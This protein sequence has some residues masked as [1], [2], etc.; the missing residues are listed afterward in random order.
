M[1]DIKVDCIVQKIETISNPDYKK[2]SSLK[3]A[4][5]QVPGTFYMGKT[6]EINF[7]CCKCN[8]LNNYKNDFREKETIKAGRLH[9]KYFSNK[10]F[11]DVF[12]DFFN[13]FLNNKGIDT[14]GS[15]IYYYSIKNKLARFIYFKC[16]KCEAKY[17]MTYSIELGEE[18]PPQPDLIHI[19]N[20]YQV[21]FDEKTFLNLYD[22][23]SRRT[24]S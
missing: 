3:I 14:N 12:G 13:L 6:W 24:N 8:S 16:K 11:L 19:N 22:S 15:T 17:L 4:N 1:I 21:D 2:L 20:L 23:L 10:H 18:R 9:Y 7:K 5:C